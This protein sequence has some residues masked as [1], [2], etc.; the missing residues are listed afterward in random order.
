MPGK[1]PHRFPEGD[2]RASAEQYHQDMFQRRQIHTVSIRKERKEEKL[3]RRR[4]P[5]STSNRYVTGD[6]LLYK[7]DSFLE[8]PHEPE[9]L[10]DLQTSMA[11][12]SASTNQ[13]LKDLIDNPDLEAKNRLLVA[14]L[15]KIL[16]QNAGASGMK[17][18]CTVPFAVLMEL[19][20]FS[21]FAPK[22]SAD[23]Y[24]CR[25]PLR[26]S[27]LIQA[28]AQLI[29]LL[30]EWIREPFA[31]EQAIESVCIILGNLLQDSAKLIPSLMPAWAT[32]VQR[33]PIS[34][35]LCATLI[36]N[37][38][39]NLGT[40]FLHDL[41]PNVLAH[42]LQE[43][44]IA[45][46]ASFI[47][48]GLSRREEEAL[49]MMCESLMLV[50]SIVNALNESMASSNSLVLVPLLR[51]TRNFFKGGPH[52]HHLLSH[53]SFIPTLLKLIE[54]GV[55]IYSL[56]VANAILSW[57]GIHGNDALAIEL[58]PALL[59]VL[60]R[61]ITSPDA[62]FP[63]KRD[64]AWAVSCSLEHEWSLDRHA[65][66]PHA[67]GVVVTWLSTNLTV[68]QADFVRSLTEL[69]SHPDMGTV[70]SA[71]IILDVLLRTIQPIR[72]L[73]ENFGGVER[74]EMICE[75]NGEGTLSEL[76]SNLAAELL[77]DF[78]EA[79]DGEDPSIAPSRGENE[80][81]FGMIEPAKPFT[82]GK[83]TSNTPGPGRGRGRG[84]T[85]PAWM[86]Q[87]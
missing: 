67:K 47:L 43:S 85:T 77:D 73:F 13:F 39:A 23:D 82:F 7:L 36:R 79:D 6:E 55:E 64:A 26:W 27:D 18:A 60:V 32:I 8:S 37:D 86:H 48:E 78:F 83:S 21:S 46:E 22:P 75:R 69:L 74:L 25:T 42:L 59:P 76:A 44:S 38:S 31:S 70:T 9:K 20:A 10:I 11:A 49:K 16:Q 40:S 84:F 33:L 81:V 53:S 87:S 72:H 35:Y 3:W 56:E 41:S 57:N 34:S 80:F 14:N 5:Q 28:D 15:T 58:I 1:K 68:P 2:P 4:Q 45:M 65:V 19:T 29:D 62:S 50:C 30:L 17:D 61:I 52:A 54:Q 63:W 71:A 12:D 24:Y 51:A 66:S